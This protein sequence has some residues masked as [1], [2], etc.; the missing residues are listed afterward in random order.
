V[1]RRSWTSRGDA[2]RVRRERA[3]ARRAS[4]RAAAGGRA[5]GVAV[6]AKSFAQQ[7]LSL[8]AA[9]TARRRARPRGVARRGRRPRQR[10]ALDLPELSSG[11][12]RRRPVGERERTRSAKTPCRPC[13]E[14]S[15]ARRR[16]EGSSPRRSRRPPARGGREQSPK[17]DGPRP[18]AFIMAERVSPGCVESSTQ[19]DSTPRRAARG[20]CPRAPS[21]RR[22]R[23]V[24]GPSPSSASS[25]RA[26]VIVSPTPGSLYSSRSRSRATASQTRAATS[27]GTPGSR[28]RARSRPRARDRVVDPV[29]RGSG[30]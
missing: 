28:V 6:G 1:A 12:S 4:R 11:S 9:G 30:A 5:L 20:R 2:S 14:H 21:A 25:A 22:E 7:L 27:S 17:A 13:E 24:S 29:A 8:H 16:V 19:R 23:V 3:G 15:A 18:R 10:R 26:H